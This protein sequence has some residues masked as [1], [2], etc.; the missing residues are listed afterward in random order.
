MQRTNTQNRSYWLW[1]T[2]L[3]EGLNDAGFSVNDRVVIE[4]DVPFTK[5]NLHELCA[6]PYLKALFGK[7]STT[8]L[9]TNEEQILYSYLDKAIS[10]RT[11][12]HLEWPSIESMENEALTG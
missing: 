5:D 8:E 12:V 6:K 10:E 4:L 2:Q 7:T 3:A 11:G 1:L 9:T